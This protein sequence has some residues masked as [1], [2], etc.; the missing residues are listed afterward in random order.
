MKF[1]SLR[2]LCLLHCAVDDF[3]GVEEG[4]ALPPYAGR[5]RRSQWGGRPPDLRMRGELVAAGL[6][7]LNEFFGEGTVQ[8]G[9][10]RAAFFAWRL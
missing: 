8:L 7:L 2:W 1:S 5:R 6:V 10:R 3:D 9:S 4:K